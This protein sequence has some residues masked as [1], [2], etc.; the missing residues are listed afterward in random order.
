MNAFT[1]TI[2]R[3]F[4]L[5]FA[6]L[7][8]LGFS[9]TL[10][11]HSALSEQRGAAETINVA[12]TLRW[13]SQNVVSET[14]RI[15]TGASSD[16]AV[17][18]A[19]LRRGE[20]AIEALMRGGQIAG[21]HVGML[22]PEYLAAIER[23]REQWA[24]Y[25]AGVGRLFD[26]L[27]AGRKVGA[28]LD[29]LGADAGTLLASTDAVVGIL[30][31]HFGELEDEAFFRL[32]LLGTVDLI[33][34]IAAFMAIR[35]QIVRPLVD[36]AGVSGEIAAGRYAARSG[37]RAGDEVGQLA[38]SFDRMAEGME[39]HTR[40][41]AADL[42]EIRRAEQALRLRE[43]AIEASS[44]GIILVKVAEGEDN[45]I[46]YANPAFE[47]MTGYPAA[48]AIGRNPRFLFGEDR[49]QPGLN[50]L[51]EAILKG[52]EARTLLRNYRKDGGLFWNELSVA[53]VRDASGNLT[54]F[55]NVFNDVTERV[56]YE[57]QLERQAT[58]DAL[59]G[60]ANRNL[61][62]DRLRQAIARAERRGSLL[63]VLFIDLDH[64]KYVND[65]LGHAV[66]D[67]LLKAVAATFS[68]CVREDDTVA[69]SGGDEFV[70]VLSDAQSEDDVLS[71]M[72]R[73]LEAVS[74]QYTVAGHELHVS[75]SI[76]A[77]LFPRDGR[78]A[79]TL[80]KNADTA[81]YRAKEGGRNRG[82]FYLE[83]MNARLGERLSLENKL[84][85]A[86]ERGELLLHYQPQVDLRSGAIVGAEALIRW[87]QPEL[88]LVP[89]DRFIG[90]AEE[91]GLIVPIG[92]WVLET[93]CAQAGAWRAAGL[94][95]IRLA[96]NLSARQFRHKR[97][98]ESIR[99]AL[100]A[101]RL[102]PDSLELEITESMI[103]HD[104]TEAIRLLQDL[105]E[106]GVRIAVDDF[107]TGYSSLGYLK[108]FPI[109]VLKIDQSFVR[110][111]ADNRSDAAI[112]RTVI[113]LAR[114]LYLHTI[115]EG[116]ETAEQADLLHAWTCDEAQGYLFSRP[117][118]AE[119][120]TTLLAARQRYQV[121][122]YSR[123]S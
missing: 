17:V 90:I 35:R 16:R 23:I 117:L 97:L 3:K 107:G 56:R 72:T 21:F 19:R 115:A 24:A 29:S 89:P 114:S 46:I 74:R 67:E 86:L 104:P 45:P 26:G 120:F 73:S 34:L 51:R 20:E 100:Q 42:D 12:G 69:R 32:Y 8:L 103:M 39:Q 65:S 113:N 96:V 25:R 79:V 44:N 36:L 111:V 80:L 83:E 82:Q 11:L 40:Q 66:G 2:S 4:A 30:T 52:R 43:R 122:E 58:H 37:Y 76:G 85:H 53:P 71:A 84:R 64:F 28:E 6:V 98:G 63:A 41:I 99:Q 77:S 15:A 78:D 105:K 109:D 101:N 112:A 119:D 7:L 88:G 18:S 110:G 92:E 106:I 13:L 68:A 9:N 108:R 48:E 102:E 1:P 50:R 123:K 91:T 22:R 116:V 55:V 75:C 94:P 93:A 70:M 61:L 31:Q 38:D 27:D 54:H 81:M 95:R 5:L 62:N 118:A 47:R 33:V 59:T 10:V 57:E 60:L 49:D 14:Q 87:H 121:K